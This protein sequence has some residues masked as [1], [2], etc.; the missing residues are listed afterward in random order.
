MLLIITLRWTKYMPDE[1]I[2]IYARSWGKS[3]SN[4][5]SLG[6]THL[7]DCFLFEFL[8]LVLFVFLRH[9]FS[10]GYFVFPL[11]VIWKSRRPCLKGLSHSNCSEFLE[12]Y[13]RCRSR[14]FCFSFGKNVCKSGPG[15][16]T[17]AVIT[18]CSLGQREGEG[19]PGL[20]VPSLDIPTALQFSCNVMIQIQRLH[21]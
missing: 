12:E 19:G 8:L 11:S 10:G 1:R 2:L 20:L 21:N 6:F 15:R 14:L 17:R 18:H 13:S 7:T 16:C 4:Q 9:F 5:V 3:P